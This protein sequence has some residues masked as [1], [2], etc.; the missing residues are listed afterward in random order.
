MI[1]FKNKN[2]VIEAYKDVDSPLSDEMVDDLNVVTQELRDLGISEEWIVIDLQCRICSHEQTAIVPA[3]T[4]DLDNLECGNCGNMTAQE[5]DAK[6]WW[7][8]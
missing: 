4:D 7:E 3:V 6:E 5:A 8:E 1:L 2:E